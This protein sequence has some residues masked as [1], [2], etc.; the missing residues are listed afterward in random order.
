M[1]N[2]S[3]KKL[4]VPS[5][6][7]E[8]FEFINENRHDIVQNWSL[9]IEIITKLDTL[10]KN[11]L[12]MCDLH[13]DTKIILE[14]IKLQYDTLVKE[15]RN[16]LSLEK[17]VQISESEILNN[18]FTIVKNES[19]NIKF[20]DK[21]TFNTV[22]KHQKSFSSRKVY[23]N[24]Q[25]KTS[26]PEITKNSNQ[27]EETNTTLQNIKNAVV[28]RGKI[29]FFEIIFDP[30]SYSK[31]V[32]NAFNMALA[33]RMKMISFVADGGTLFATEYDSSNLELDHSVLE[34]TPVQFR[35]LKESRTRSM[36]FISE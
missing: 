15:I 9:L 8:I 32:L 2:N 1:E 6:Y 21:L 11:T 13:K 30:N 12:T 36:D 5:T 23:D 14:A 35:K 25:G 24:A 22:T 10:L 17:L 16:E 3:N 20:L 34:I 31:T 18:F 29:E 19:Q 7:F 33:F 26:V 28:A 4:T 27:F